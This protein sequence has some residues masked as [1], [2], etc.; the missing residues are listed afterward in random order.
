IYEKLIAFCAINETGTNYPEHIYDPFS[1][2]EDSFYERLS[3]IQKENHEKKQ[4]ER[5]NKVEFISATKK[6]TGTSSGASTSGTSDEAA[7][8]R[9]SKW[10]VTSSGTA[11]LT[12][13]Q[14]AVQTIASVQAVVAANS[15]L[16]TVQVKKT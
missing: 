8:R 14:S 15:K 12:I 11:A 4:R 6:T 13:P 2:T 7:R 16:V 3:K 9:R 1:W 5:S 10:D